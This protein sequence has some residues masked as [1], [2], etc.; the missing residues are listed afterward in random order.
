M[1]QPIQDFYEEYDKQ[2]KKFNSAREA[3]KRGEDVAEMP[4][5]LAGPKKQ[6]DA[7]HKTIRDTYA[8]KKMTAEAKRKVIDE[9]YI[10]MLETA[11]RAL[12]DRRKA[13]GGP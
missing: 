4:P 6:L 9:T 13:Y 11:Q 5:R 2:E 12:A 1:S 8:D 10:R 7:L 3:K